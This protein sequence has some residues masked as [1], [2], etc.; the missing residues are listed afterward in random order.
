VYDAKNGAVF[1]RL[2]RHKDTPLAVAWSADG[3]MLA[4]AG[5]D[6]QVLVYDGQSA[7]SDLPQG[8]VDEPDEQVQWREDLDE[9]RTGRP[10]EGNTTASGDGNTSNVSAWMPHPLGGRTAFF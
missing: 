8:D 1:R 10:S 2:G 5:M 3:L 4:S 7:L 9:F 6:K